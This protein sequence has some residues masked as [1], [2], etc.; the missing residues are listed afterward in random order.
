MVVVLHAK[1]QPWGLNRV[2]AYTGHTHTHRLAE[3]PGVARGDL[4]RF[5]VFV[6]SCLLKLPDAN[7][8]FQLF[9]LFTFII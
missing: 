4:K 9:G 1:F 2:A 7:D 5:S 6:F 3:L 8:K